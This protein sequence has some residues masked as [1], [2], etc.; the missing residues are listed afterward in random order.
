MSTAAPMP[1]FQANDEFVAIRHIRLSSNDSIKFGEDI[2]GYNRW[3]LLNWY[4]RHFIG[5]KGHPWTERKMRCYRRRKGVEEVV[6]EAQ[7]PKAT[8]PKTKKPAKRRIK[9]VVK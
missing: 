6:V 3:K 2:K 1:S 8:T 4:R 5:V 7:A 9:K